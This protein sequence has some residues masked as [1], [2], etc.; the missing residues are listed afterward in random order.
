M[1]EHWLTLQFPCL[2]G[3]NRNILH[4]DSHHLEE[5]PLPQ[6]DDDMVETHNFL[7]N[8]RGMPIRPSRLPP[9]APTSQKSIHLKNL[10]PAIFKP[11]NLQPTKIRSEA[12]S[13][14]HTLLKTNSSPMKMDSWKMIHFLLGMAY[15]QGRYVSFKEGN[16]PKCLAGKPRRSSPG[17]RCHQWPPSD[18][19]EKAWSM[20]GSGHHF[21]VF[22]GNEKNILSLQICGFIYIFVNLKCIYIYNIYKFKK[23]IHNIP[24]LLYTHINMRIHL[25]VGWSV[26]WT[27][28]V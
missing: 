16:P 19:R 11:L 2:R 27:N 12:F 23:C 18:Q 8:S 15:F 10:H 14:R 22:G 28:I 26:P 21:G 24:W 17:H 1:F 25:Q 3:W 13:N 5:A 20:V 6:Y 9:T 7:T 4:C